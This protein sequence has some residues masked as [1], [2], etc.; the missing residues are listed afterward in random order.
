MY[1][2]GVHRSGVDKCRMPEIS[3]QLVGSIRR[4]LNVP[5][6]CS[7]KNLRQLIAA[8]FQISCD[9]LRLVSVGATLKD[10]DEPLYLADKHSM[11]AFVAPRLPSARHRDGITRGSGEYLDAEAEDE[12]FRLRSG[13]SRGERF[14]ARIL[15]QQLKVPDVVLQLLFS[16]RSQT[17]ITFVVWLCLCP[18]A[19]RLHIGPLYVLGSIVAVIYVNLGTRKPGEQSAYS[20]FNEGIRALPG[21][22]DAD[23]ID[24]QM[25]RGQM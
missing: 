11:L 10:D 17:L 19:A 4:K 25:R 16:I 24:D 13:A 12:R 23:T 2:S 1:H 22:L 21:Q 7:V 20:V 18:I 3:V 9:R 14:L 8:E 5:S 6:P 15:Q